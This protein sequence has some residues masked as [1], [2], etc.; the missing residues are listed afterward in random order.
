M[1]AR[2]ELLM[3]IQVDRQ[4]NR[5]AVFGSYISAGTIPED[6][7]I[8]VDTEALSVR[9]SSMT[10]AE[11]ERKARLVRF[12]PKTSFDSRTLLWMVIN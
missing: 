6:V 3:T 5:A 1:T 8:S 2:I 11:A 12:K 9:Q 10:S 4:M 7:N